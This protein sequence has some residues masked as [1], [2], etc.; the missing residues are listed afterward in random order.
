MWN[1]NKKWLSSKNSEFPLLKVRNVPEQQKVKV[2]LN[3]SQTR[4]SGSEMFLFWSGTRFKNHLQTEIQKQHVGKHLD[5]FFSPSSVFGNCFCTLD[6]A[7]LNHDDVRTTLLRRLFQGKIC[8]IFFTAEKWNF[9]T[10]WES[11]LL[12]RSS[13]ASVQPSNWGL[14]FLFVL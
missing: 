2:N 9:N 1:R 3:A 7:W 13:V 10:C 6:E 4:T 12:K 11:F 5:I 8:I 14:S